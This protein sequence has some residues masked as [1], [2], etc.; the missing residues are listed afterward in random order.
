MFVGAV[1]AA[2]LAVTGCGGVQR[3]S[4]HPAE[5][6]LRYGQSASFELRGYLKDGTVQTISEG[7]TWA[8]S[9]PSVVEIKADTG[10]ARAVGVAGTAR[11]YTESEKHPELQVPPS[12][13]ARVWVYTPGPTT[14]PASVKL[15]QEVGQI[16]K[17]RLDF[18][19]IMAALTKLRDTQV[20]ID[21]TS[22]R[23]GLGEAGFEPPA[24]PKYKDFV[25]S[26]LA[27][28]DD[29][30]F[31]EGHRAGSDLKD[32]KVTDLQVIRLIRSELALAPLE[33]R[34]A[35]LH[36]LSVGYGE[37]GAAMARGFYVAADLR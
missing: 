36:G 4:I 19:T 5:A 29:E 6:N 1:L 25:A 30:A 24:P 35:W 22:F 28:G 37:G 21:E 10:A 33:K 12:D 13:G 15:G 27:A 3:V 7:F 26:L 17:E 23:S 9:E 20:R 2:V 14:D 18:L 34:W 31:A 16:L 32:R 8:S 11:I